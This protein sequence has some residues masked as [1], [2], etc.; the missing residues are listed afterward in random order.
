MKTIKTIN[1][2]TGERRNVPADEYLLNEIRLEIANCA[3][4]IKNHPDI[5][6]VRD[7]SRF[8]T[9]K[10]LESLEKSMQDIKNK[11]TLFTD[12]YK[13]LLHNIDMLDEI[14]SNTDNTPVECI[15][16]GQQI[17]YKI[18]AN[19][20]ESINAHDADKNKP[21]DCCEWKWDKDVQENVVYAIV[22]CKG[23]HMSDRI[24]FDKF[25]LF[26]Y[27]PYCGRKIKLIN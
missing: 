24:I 7:G 3:K 26:N 25:R 19:I 6:T 15:L 11:E 2:K 4:T 22:A 8:A 14:K 23:T 10:V 20:I 27:C 12:F 21:D 18:A 9:Q 13:M 5:G 16:I 1:L 17:G